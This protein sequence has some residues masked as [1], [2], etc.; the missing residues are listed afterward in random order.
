MGDKRK[1]QESFTQLNDAMLQYRASL[2]KEI[3]RVDE[4][5]NLAKKLMNKFEDGFLEE[6]M[7]IAEFL[8]I[9][10]AL[11]QSRIKTFLH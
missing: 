1:V 11:E 9:G 5:V 7:A 4:Q 8:R 2:E 3:E 10:G 6:A